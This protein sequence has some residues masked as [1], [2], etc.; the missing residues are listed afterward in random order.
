VKPDYAIILN[1]FAQSGR[2]HSLAKPL[3][4]ISNRIQI[5]LTVGREGGTKEAEAAVSEGA[6]VIV[7]AGGDGTINEVLNGML[8]SGLPLGILPVGSVNVFARELKIPLKWSDAWDVIQRGKYR[9][10]DVVR[11]D[12]HRGGKSVRRHFVQ[13]A[14]FGFDAEIVKQVT[15]E[16]KRKWGPLSYVFEGLKCLRAEYPPIKVKMDG[17]ESKECAFALIGNGKFYGGPFH[18]FKKASF[19]DGMM[20]VCLFEKT[21]VI[22]TVKYLAA[23][24]N[25]SHD[26]T[27]GIIY[28][29]A[30][31]VEITSIEHVPIEVDGEFVGETPA[32][33]TVIPKG[34]KI[35]VP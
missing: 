23:I 35:L 32:K 9:E 18:V 22:P 7:A 34:L 25:G 24:A 15:W 17:G 12:Y 26:R 27:K 3:A 29:H 33:L 13:L 14:G 16:K 11:I 8:E 4:E 1:P 28:K 19:D 10:I 2:S 20:D 31:K 21:G 6:K 30:K 5:K